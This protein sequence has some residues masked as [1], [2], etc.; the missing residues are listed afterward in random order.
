MCAVC[1]RA[2]Q[3]RNAIITLDSRHI[4]PIHLN[5]NDHDDD[6][7]NKTENTTDKYLMLCNA[8]GSLPISLR[9]IMQA[10]LLRRIAAPLANRF[11]SRLLHVSALGSRFNAGTDL[12]QRDVLGWSQRS[13]WMYRQTRSMS[14][15][16]TTISDLPLHKAI[17]ISAS[18]RL[19]VR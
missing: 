7:D 17:D 15:T 19:V 14:S 18:M 2:S 16:T 5:H 12:I 10:A 9:T 6:N 3:C 11:T 4:D 13:V 8:C 1:V